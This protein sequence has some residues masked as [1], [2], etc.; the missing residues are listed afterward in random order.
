MASYYQLAFLGDESSVAFS[1][2][3][4]RFFELL[5]ERGLSSSLIDV[6]SADR[7]LLSSE[8]GG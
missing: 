2:I 8:E 3:R 7:I 1:R 6:L 4:E 5:R